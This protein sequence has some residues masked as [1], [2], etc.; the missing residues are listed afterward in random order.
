MPRL[1]ESAA[2]RP[3]YTPWAQNQ[4]ETYCLT[5]PRYRH[6][7]VAVTEGNVTKNLNK[8]GVRLWTAINAV[9]SVAETRSIRSRTKQIA[10]LDPM[11]GAAPSV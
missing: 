4:I 3:E 7:P 9:K 6:R 1:K 11:S 8:T 10:K 5:L 2:P